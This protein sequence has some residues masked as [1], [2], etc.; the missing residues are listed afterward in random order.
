MALISY[1][2]WQLQVGASTPLSQS[3]P[4]Y[5]IDIDNGRVVKIDDMGGAKRLAT[6]SG[7]L[8]TKADRLYGMEKP[9]NKYK[10]KN[11]HKNF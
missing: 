4:D 2:E 9:R 7:E 11:R 8:E 6:A 1:K 3:A 5:H 10:K